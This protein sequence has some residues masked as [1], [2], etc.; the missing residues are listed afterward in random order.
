[1]IKYIKKYIINQH[2]L[3]ESIAIYCTPFICSLIV[4]QLF[5]LIENNTELQNV[6]CSVLYF[7]PNF[8]LTLLDTILFIISI[9][10]SFFLSKF[11]WDLSNFRWLKW[12]SSITFFITLFAFSMFVPKFDDLSRLNKR[13]ILLAVSNEIRKSDTEEIAIRFNHKSREINSFFE[14]RDFDIYEIEN[15]SYDSVLRQ[16]KLPMNSIKIQA[17]IFS[18]I[19]GEILGKIVI[20]KKQKKNFYLM[21]RDNNILGIDLEIINNNP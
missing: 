11:I 5:L 21:D 6:D 10:G 12:T 18:E 1:M 14:N 15:F 2:F 16:I 13:R 20:S 17:P 4:Y 19:K 7:H 9:I 8:F 3:I